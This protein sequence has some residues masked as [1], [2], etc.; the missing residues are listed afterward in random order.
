MANSPILVLGSGSWG[1]ALAIVLAVNGNQVRLW[2]H[3]QQ[4]LQ[5]IAAS[6]C[7]E[8]Y[9]PGITL[10]ENVQCVADIEQA[11]LGVT[12]VLIVVPSHAFRSLL[13][14]FKD[15]FAEKSIRLAWATKGLDPSNGLLLPDVAS[16]IFG[17]DKPMAILSGPSFAKE[18]A[19]AQPTA[20]T[21]AA[22]DTSFA[23]DLQQR[24]HNQYF[25]VYRS[26]D[27]TGVSVCGAVKNV[28]AVACGFVMVWL[29]GLMPA[30][31]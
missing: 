29:T 26:D 31:L 6:R 17:K 27:L 13:L 21:I 18:V 15:L 2:G 8:R 7:N 11:L 19:N 30:P 14:Q 12:D 28:L 10:P 25:R 4:H 16:S 3:N 1:T 22:N 23:V 5:Q 24:F 9:L 20:V